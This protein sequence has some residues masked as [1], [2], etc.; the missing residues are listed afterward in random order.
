MKVEILI[1]AYLA[2]SIAMICFNI[3]CIFLFRH[4]EQMITR[5]RNDY[6]G[7]IRRQ[8]A[9][10]AVTP[11]H[12]EFML[13]NL[14][15]VNGMLAF[16]QSLDILQKDDSAGLERYLRQL[17]PVFRQLG[18]KYDSKNE[19]RAAYFP[20]LIGKYKLFKGENIREIN[21]TL[22]ELLRH[23]SIYSR[24][25]AMSAICSIGNCENVV[26]AL[27][28]IDHNGFYHHK[29]LITDVLL[30]F[31]GDK[32]EFN[33][34]LWEHLGDHSTDIQTA[35]LDYFRFSTGSMCEQMLSLFSGK[36]DKELQ[37]CAI[38]YFGRYPYEPA[39]PH[40]IWF[41]ESRDEANWEFAAIAAT[42]LAS[43]PSERTV[44]VLKSRLASRNWYVRYNASQSLETLGVEYADMVDV[45]ESE[46]R[47]AGEMMR[48]RLSQKRLR[49][50][51]EAE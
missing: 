18:E 2:V 28:I 23:P 41:A 19:L 26:K 25:N 6:T 11:K 22:F 13:K 8:M 34:L 1:Y 9:L 5:R 43:Y 49:E 16:E 50:R 21:R 47:F 51:E 27:K 12:K 7:L 30:S 45:F 35:I 3:V 40:L 31:Q 24:E 4:N 32:D 33:R 36:Y 38:R 14:A 10:E 42:A 44:D 39:Y 29:K 46:D 17:V 20:Y 15:R 48:Y 37:F